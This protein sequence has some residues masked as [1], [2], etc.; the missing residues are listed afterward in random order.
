[1][2]RAP[3]PKPPAPRDEDIELTPHFESGPPPAEKPRKPRAKKSPEAEPKPKKPRAKRDS[4]IAKADKPASEKPRA[5]KSSTPRKQPS[6]PTPT[7]SVPREEPAR[8]SSHDPLRSASLNHARWSSNHVDRF[9][10]PAAPPERQRA[11]DSVM[12]T[13]SVVIGDPVEAAVVVI[14]PPAPPELPAEAVVQ[15]EAPA[16]DIALPVPHTLPITEVMPY[17]PSVP[18]ASCAT[19]VDPLRA[20]CVRATDRGL[21]FFCSRVCREAQRAA[22]RARRV[23]PPPVVEAKVKAPVVSAPL[24]SVPPSRPAPPSVEPLARRISAGR[25]T[26]PLWPWLTALAAGA[27]PWLQ[28]PF[29][30]PIAAGVLVASAGVF[31]SRSAA[32]REQAGTVGWLAPVLAVASLSLAA[33]LADSGHAKL[34]IGTAAV[35][36]LATWAREHWLERAHAIVAALRAEIEARSASRVRVVGGDNQLAERGLNSLRVG[37][38]VWIEQGSVVPVDGVIEHG[39]AELLPYPQARLTVQRRVGGAVLGGALVIRGALRV[40]ATAVGPKR[41]LLRALATPDRS[42]ESVAPSAQHAARVRALGPGVAALVGAV[43]CAAITPGTPSTKLAGLGAA[44][45]V[46][47]MLA[48]SRGVLNALQRAVIR[49]AARGVFFRDGAALERAGQIDTAVLRVEGTLVPRAYTLVEV[50]ALAPDVARETLL[51]WALGAEAAADGHPLA[52]AVRRHAATLGIEPATVRRLAYAR[53]A[54]V[55]G[56]TDGHGAL[57]LGSRAALLQAGVSV[58]VA[59]REAQQAEQNGH[60]VVLLALGGHVRGLFVFAQELRG[61]ARLAVQS[62]FD[63]G[64]EVELVAGDHRNTVEALARTLD[65]LQ[66][67]AELTREQRE[68]ELR[69]LRD[70]EARVAA[71]G[72]AED[73]GGM[74][75]AAD[76]GVCLEGAPE[77]HAPGDLRAIAHD[78][79]T[80]SG[81]LRD[82]TYALGV[83]REA[84]RALLQVWAMAGLACLLALLSALSLT[85]AWA[86]VL[87]ALALD[88]ACLRPSMLRPRADQD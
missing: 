63:L 15:P 66:V 57:V 47:P 88:A 16:N 21:E 53:G 52:R 13:H 1:M 87:A 3:S 11:I 20:A 54:G 74:L 69:R 25:A 18:C 43:V 65:V 23:E 27:M 31:A 30:T 14:E 32:T 36:L 58:A 40:R 82:A 10:N 71:I 28:Q 49:G 72:N 79:I 50:H 61:E 85:P 8:D 77:V 51:A 80:A 2:T 56:L 12:R 70:G 29:A 75:T 44:L 7:P 67:K 6:A 76:V 60:K 22:E 64:L 39:D 55:S 42:L 59:D 86:A 41:A 78:L 9:A 24:P 73:A 33:V 48:A 35:A 45:A 5:R 62:L 34:W 46:L 68:A 38:Q 17:Q 4:G 83:A 84:R 26:T 37:D 19:G 81:D